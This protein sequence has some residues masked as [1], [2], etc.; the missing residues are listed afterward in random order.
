MNSTPTSLVQTV[1]PYCGC[2]CAMNLEIQENKI[3]KI[4]GIKRHPVS[5]GFLCIKGRRANEFVDHPD[6]LKRPMMRIGKKMKEVSWETAIAHT[7]KELKRIKEVYGPNSIGFLTSSKC[8]NE[9]N[10]LLM[11]FASAVIG[12]NNLDSCARL[13]HSTTAA[14]LAQNLG[15]GVM[16]NSIAE[17][18]ESDCIL[19][20]GSN[21]MSSH[22]LVG[23]KMTQAKKK[24]GTKIIVVDPR[25]TEIAKK[26]DI[27]L[28]LRP[29]TDAPLVNAMM[30]IILEEGLEDMEFIKTRTKGFEYLTKIIRRF[31]PE[32]AAKITGLEK[33]DIIEAGR[34]YGK[35]ERGGHLLCNGNDP[36]PHGSGE[37]CQS[38]Q[39]GHAHWELR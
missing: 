30:R 10:Y 31:T 9:E 5:D 25:R 15:S 3:I 16:T 6:R 39:P 32:Y 17:A 8:T 33:R 21:T 19:I 36:A 23:L 11:K 2:G 28:Q 35:A 38:I 37:H 22:P 1:C 20:F 4:S 13:C 18:G 14:A 12:T 7:A 34:M 29:G 24:R 27:H 26:A